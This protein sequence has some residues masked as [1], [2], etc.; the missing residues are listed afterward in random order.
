MENEN[1][2]EAE[3]LEVELDTESLLN[4]VNVAEL[5]DE[6]T[7]DKIG[8]MALEGYNIDKKSREGWEMK[9]DEWLE[10]ALQVAEHKTFPWPGAANVKYPLITTAAL[11]FSARSYPALLPGTNLVRGRVIGKDPDG[12][13]T[14]RAI[15]VGK[16]MTYQL[17]E[18]MED[19]EEEMDRLLFALPIVGCM[20]KKTYYCP[21]KERNVSE[22]VYPKELVVN[23]WAKSLED[24]QRITHEINLTSNDVYERVESGVFLD[25]P[26]T[27]GS[28]EEEEETITDTALGVSKPESKDSTTPYEVLEQ[29][30]YID[31]DDDDYAE[32]YV[33]TLS[34]ENGKVA[35]IVAAYTQRDIVYNQD[36]SIIR[37]NPTSYYTKYSFVPAPDGGFY[38]IG[39]GILLGPINETINTLINQLLDAG[40]LS[41]MQAGFIA[42]GIR[43]KGGNKPFTLG[44]WKYVNSVGGDLKS[45]ILPLPVREPSQVLFNLLGMMIDAGNKL[46]SVT[47]IM[48][49]DVP[50]QNTKA[51][52]A[53]NAMEQGMKVFTS[54]HKRVHRSLS[55]EFKKLFRLNSLYMDE[56]EYFTILDVGQEQQAQ[57]GRSDYDLENVDVKP[58]SDPNV[59]TEE[60]KIGKIKVLAQLLQI[61]TINPQE[62]TKRVLEAT[63]QPNIPA[64]MEMP[65]PKPDPEVELEKEKFKDESMR[66]WEELSLKKKEIEAKALKDIADAEAAELGDQLEEYKARMDAWQK[67][68]AANQKLEQ[69]RQNHI[70]QMKMK[71]EEHQLKLKHQ[72]EVMEQKAEQ[73][74]QKTVSLQRGADGKISGATVGP[75][76]KKVSLKRDKTG[77]L[78]GAEVS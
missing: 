5:L 39:F 2:N 70:F 22:V 78:S 1:Y 60:Q 52:V 6:D 51:T 19:W 46:S 26:F 37:I 33:V 43:I 13:K 40:S 77:K 58:T 18:Q 53:M 50:G 61:G 74:R 67:A 31:L 59:A 76:A 66:A 41:N 3:E 36:G 71:D 38:D 16:H 35:R 29:C 24:A 9:V 72:R 20:F 27:C 12:M 30:C 75:S 49:G 69:E 23:Y 65:P 4:S 56:N 48:V 68:E 42:K 62:Y 28:R 47:E 7:L 21:V 14:E 11:Q 63:E 15:R 17:L 8:Q 34:K 10:L 57:I 45:S 44:E 55:K 32:P 25:I 64:L 54:I 73:E